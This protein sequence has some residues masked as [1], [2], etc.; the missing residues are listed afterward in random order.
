MIGAAD[1][2]PMAVAWI[3]TAAATAIIAAAGLAHLLLDFDP[4][5]L[6]H[7]RWLQAWVQAYG[8]PPI[9]ILAAI[10][11]AVALFIA[12]CAVN[13][14]SFQDR[15]YGYAAFA[16]ARELR[17]MKPTVTA[18]RGMV[19]GRVGGRL[20]MSDQP[21]SGM[22]AAPAGT[23]KT[24]N[25]IIPSVL[26]SDD[27]SVVVNDP[28]GEVWDRTAGYRASLGPV[29][30]LDPGAG[31]AGSH[32][33][34]PIDPRDLPPDAAGRGDLIDRMVTMLIEGR[35]SE[36]FV[37]APRSALSAWLLYCI[38]EA[39][40]KG[41]VPTL[42]DAAARFGL[43][44]GEADEED[45]DPVRTELEAAAE[46][47][48]QLGWPQR[49]VVGL[50]ALAAFDYRTRSNVI[51]S[52]NAALRIFQNENVVEITSRSDFRL[53]DL[54]GRDG[55]PISVYVVVPAFDQ[56][57]FGKLTALLVETA[58]R[59][60]TQ[61]MP[62]GDDKPVRFIL[63]EV[64]FLPP[65][66]AVSL[67]PAITRGYG[68]SFLFAFQDFGQVVGKWGQ[69]ALDNMLTNTAYKVVFGQN[70]EQTARYFSELIGHQTRERV[71]QS[72]QTGLG[73]RAFATGN[74]SENA[75]G[76]ALVTAQDVKNLA[77]GQVLVL[78]QQN[79]ARPIKARGAY[80]PKIPRL[81]RRSAI[82]APKVGAAP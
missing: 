12:G 73:R 24:E 33:F 15:R 39:E 71:S 82:A 43:L 35:E 69:G 3:F 18:R 8:R 4:S 42:G 11:A 48:R 38:Y 20:L 49:V 19:L 68:A 23:G 56:E 10:G 34:N 66:R 1:Q 81:R 67:G 80:V 32:C 30:R 28:K 22:V 79:L 76:Y 70:H 21:L 9:E 50:T 64:A 36:F 16:S 7:W 75:E 51:G 74:R 62:G 61:R 40:E 60:L 27:A 45:S 52:V 5:R 55:R 47:A 13:P 63:D 2:R 25:V 54:R 14:F 17:R 53:E 78:V 29:F 77:V 59:Y 58:T 44:G 26:M 6:D 31:V 37:S 46:V 65:V 41:A 72:R 57:A